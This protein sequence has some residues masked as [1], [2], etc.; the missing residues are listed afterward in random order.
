M[1]MS[2][3]FNFGPPRWML[4]TTVRNQFHYTVPD[5]IDWLTELQV[6]A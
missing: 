3:N 5:L 1:Q 4:A 2:S 6:F